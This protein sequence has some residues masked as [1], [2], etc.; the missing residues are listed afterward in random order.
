MRSSAPS[1]AKI[2]KPAIPPVT[3]ISTEGIKPRLN[4][5]VAKKMPT[6]YFNDEKKSTSTP[7][8]TFIGI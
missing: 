3:V 5:F 2:K 4:V 1:K 8:N 6:M 7:L